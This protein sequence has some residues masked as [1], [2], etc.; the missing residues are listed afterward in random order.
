MKKNANLG[1]A[2]EQMV[3]R[4]N[5][6]Y[7]QKGIALV[8]KIPTEVTVMRKG[9]QITGAFFKSRST[10]DFVGLS[11]GRGI[12]FDAKSTKQTTRFPL[13]NIEQ[14]Q[15][16]FLKKWK[17]QGGISFILVHFEKHR[18]TYLLQFDDLLE[19]WQKAQAGGAKS[20]KYEWFPIHC[21][22]VKSSNGVLLDYIRLLKVV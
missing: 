13:N 12:A 2:F 3:E 16:D 8:D 5:Q 22:Q 19:A 1:K 18:E 21:D 14:H 7:K 20:I 11:H 17:D 10:V 6:V 15:I 9:K 4:S